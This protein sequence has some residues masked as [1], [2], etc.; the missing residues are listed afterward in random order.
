MSNLISRR[1]DKSL[2]LHCNWGWDGKYDGYFASKAFDAV[3]GCYLADDIAAVSQTRG[4][5]AKNSLGGSG[6]LLIINRSNYEKA[7]SPVRRFV[8]CRLRQI[9]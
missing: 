1:V 3:K 6:S 4:A 5:N 7:Y 9:V 2:L 8:G